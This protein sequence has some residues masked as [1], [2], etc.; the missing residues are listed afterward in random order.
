MTPQQESDAAGPDDCHRTNFTREN[1]TF[2]CPHYDR[3]GGCVGAWLVWSTGL[4]SRCTESG[5]SHDLVGHVKATG[6]EDQE[7]QECFRASNKSS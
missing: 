3:M 6:G 2:L 4:T 5:G 1:C 7:G